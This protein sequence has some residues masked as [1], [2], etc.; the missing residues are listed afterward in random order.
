MKQYL[1]ILAGKPR[2]VLGILKAM[3]ARYGNV[4]VKEIKL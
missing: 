1:L 4:P 2:F 3:C